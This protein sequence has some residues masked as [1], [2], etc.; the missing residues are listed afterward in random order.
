VTLLAFGSVAS[1]GALT[2][3]ALETAVVVGGFQQPTAMAFYGDGD[4]LVLEKASGRVRNVVDFVL[5]STDALDLSVDSTGERGLLGIAVHPNFANNGFVYLFY[6]PSASP[7][8][9]KVVRYTLNGGTLTNATPILT[10]NSTVDS[11]AHNGGAMT[12]GQDG[13]LYIVVGDRSQDTGLQNGS[14]ATVANDTSVIFRIN[15]D[16]STPNSGN[17][18][19]GAGLGKYYAYGIRNSFGIA[20]DPQSGAI[21]DTENGNLSYDEVNR[22]AA[23][24][25]SGWLP[26]MG[27]LSRNTNTVMD[28]TNITGGAYSDPE[29]SWFETIAPTGLAFLSGSALGAAYNDD[30]VVAAFNGGTISKLQLNAGR[31]GIVSPNASLDDLV[32][33][34]GDNVSGIAFGSDFGSITDLKVGPFDGRLYGVSITRGEVFVIRQKGDVPPPPGNVR[35]LAVTALK[36]TKRVKLTSKHPSRVAK[37]KV[38][39]Q[40]RGPETETISNATLLEQLVTLDVTSLVG[41]CPSPAVQLVPPKKFPIALKSKKKLNLKFQVTIDCA[42]DP[43][44]SKKSSDH[45]DFSFE[46]AVHR[47]VLD[48]LPDTHVLDDVC[49]HPPLAGNVDPNPNG[50]IKDLGCG[51]KIDKKNFGGPVVMDVTQK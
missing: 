35:D 15:D 51:G 28:L 5:Q 7:A 25:N 41:S 34:P 39:I 10:L 42:N 2:D 4:F 18:F 16:G 33:D 11:A 8:G 9:N 29:F 26:L 38:T 50:K 24:F 40:N 6:T 1:A 47:E 44:A 12:F 48:T 30:L 32:A 27:P 23:G 45:D 22:V 3:S 14:G 31:T 13:K 43:E 37:V 49:P 21:W 20:V 46:A 36:P 17:P 19:S